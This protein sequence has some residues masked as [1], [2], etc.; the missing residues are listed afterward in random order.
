MNSIITMLF[1]ALGCVFAVT[2]FALEYGKWK[3]KSIII[4]KEGKIIRSLSFFFLMCVFCGIFSFG[5]F[6]FASRLKTALEVLLITLI[7]VLFLLINIFVDF[8]IT[9]KGK[10]FLDTERKNLHK[11]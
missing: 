3:R 5:F 4:T 8:V 1:G 7:F 2:F 10:Y 9:S 11:K 6:S